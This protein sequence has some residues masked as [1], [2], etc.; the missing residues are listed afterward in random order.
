MTAGESSVAPADAAAVRRRNLGSVLRHVA[1]HGPCARTEIAASTGLAHGSVTALVADLMDRGLL[2]EDAAQRSGTRGR[3]GR[4]VRLNPARAL[5][6]AVQISADHLRVRAADLAGT[7]RWD[8]AEPLRAPIAPGDMADAIAALLGRAVAATVEPAEPMRQQSRIVRP[9][10]PDSGAR[11]GSADPV[12]GSAPDGSARVARRTTAGAGGADAAAV[13]ESDAAEAVSGAPVVVRVVVAMAGPVRD[14]SARTVVVAPDFGWLR[15]VRLGELITAR[16]PGLGCAVE[17]VNDGNAAA[18][19]EFHARGRGRERVVLIEA[20]T[21]IGGGVVTDG[22]IEIGSHGV[23]GEPGH[24]PVGLDGPEC[25]CGAR[26]C[27]VVYAGP[28]AVLGAAGLREVLRDKGVFAASGELMALLEAGDERA[29]GAAEVAGRALGAAVQSIS[30]LLDV[31]AVVLGGALA[32]W[33]PWLLP[34]MELSLSGRRALVPGLRLEVVPAVLGADA[35][36]LG[37]GEFARRA[38]LSD[39]AVVPSL[40]LG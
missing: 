19:A 37:A 5:T 40:P 18:L 2:R 35:I 6:L 27:L 36:L 1:D 30:S 12:A 8:A 38:V 7:T 28:E 13:P 32:Q 17:V 11:T 26:G 39:P 34:A 29:V 31:D 9:V 14:D 16:L 10:G 15:P 24:M 23:A 3:P 22:R 21:G 33:F 20:G 4:P 25:V